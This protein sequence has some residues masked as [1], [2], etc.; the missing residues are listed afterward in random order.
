MA[1]VVPVPLKKTSRRKQWTYH[2]GPRSSLRLLQGQLAE[3]GCPEAQVALAKQLLND[4]ENEEKEENARLAVYWLIK[5]SE[6]GHVDATEILQHCL[7][8]GQ[9][10]SEQ[11]FLDVHKCLKMSQDEKL[12]RRAA[13]QLFNSLSA[14][15]DYITTD[16]LRRRIV[17]LQRGRS[18]PSRHRLKGLSDPIAGSSDEDE[19]CNHDWT[20]RARQSYPGEKLTEDCLVSAATTYTRGQLPLVQRVLVLADP[21]RGQLEQLGFMQRSV[22]HPW[23]TIVLVY[24]K[25]LEFFARRGSALLQM[26]IPTSPVHTLVL[27]GCYWLAGAE[28]L[29][30]LFALLIFYTSFGFMFVSSMEMLQQEREFRHFRVWSQLFLSHSSNPAD[31][32]GGFLDSGQ[33]ERRFLNGGLSQFARFFAALLFYLVSYP[34]VNSTW[35]P[36]AEISVI[37]TVLSVITLFSFMEKKIDGLMILSFA[38]N[39]LARYPYDFD[40]VVQG[41]QFLDLRAPAFASAIVGRS[42]EFCLTYRSLLHLSVGVILLRM[43]LRN[44]WAGVCRALIPH[45]VA[46]A[47]WQIAVLSA[48]SATKFGLLRAAFSIV[49]LGFCLPLIGVLLLLLPALAI[50]KTLAS[51]TLLVKAATSTL[52]A[53]LPFFISWWISRLH[54][55]GTVEAGRLVLVLQLI[56]SVVAMMVLLYPISSTTLNGVSFLQEEQP[57]PPGAKVEAESIPV[58]NV[59][60]SWDAYHSHCHQP[61]WE[62]S[63]IASTQLACSSLAGTTV[64]WNGYVTSVE[65]TK[66]RNLLADLLQSLPSVVGSALSCLFGE[67]VP[68]VCPPEASRC[69][70]QQLTGQKCHLDAWAT[71]EVTLKVKMKAKRMWGGD[72]E[73]QVVAEHFF[74]NFTAAL[75]PQDRVWFSGQL[76]A[77]GLGG[78]KPQLRLQQI[79]CLDCHR[80]DLLLMRKPTFLMA[81]VTSIIDVGQV[82]LQSLVGFTLGP[83]IRFT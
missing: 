32:G 2:D 29:A 64:S 42:V 81:S 17:V 21:E 78:P 8:I 5:A 63:S 10:I 23:A 67:Q 41:W 56:C 34:L 83:L 45:C 48:E 12:A 36:H 16:Q 28:S 9:G 46:L 80:Q 26:L 39:V 66:H 51:T 58:P 31:L 70:L 71:T 79:D 57:M 69:Q 76:L 37:A 49:G 43:A 3:D 33:A 53:A 75:Q 82:A 22:L 7:D 1:G 6:Q 72:A 11:N 65:V 50:L 24:L 13:R 4:T 20:S 18:S 68:L 60:L 59:G 61:A 14:G 55:R 52:V 74:T 19:Q 35:V 15:Q 62:K 27:L 54:R 73:V 77:D 25:L 40:A 44:G 30:W 38:L 47:W